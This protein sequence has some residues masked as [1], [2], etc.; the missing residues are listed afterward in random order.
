MP[1]TE[2]N[3]QN[4]TEN[5]IKNE[6][7]NNKSNGS[8]KILLGV[9]AL[10]LIA[11]LCFAFPF[12]QK[13]MQEDKNVTSEVTT[14]TEVNNCACDASRFKSEYESL[15]NQ[16]KSNGVDKHLE[17]SIPDEN[18]IEYIDSTRA[19]QILTNGTGVIY[20]GF[21]ECPWCRNLV[22]T[23]IDVA[24]EN[25]QGKILYLN[26]K[27]ERDIKKLDEEGNIATEK[28]G[29]DNYYEILNLL[30]ENASTYNG[31]E[32]ETIKRLYFPTVVFVKNG[33]IV[34]FHEG[35]VDSQEDASVMMT[36]EQQKELK[37][38]LQEDYAKV[39]PEKCSKTGC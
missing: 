35:T 19:K 14:K 32:D 15:N 8:I 5:E 21:P 20:F 28:E 18:N 34:A 13:A 23:L 9:I 31:L 27:E 22:P 25:G 39:Y 7:N 29:T 26:N 24:N 17:I 16:L 11:N 36:V 38:I 33:E 12:I 1:N 6:N 30:G 3:N 37:K 4:Q 10:L 2:N